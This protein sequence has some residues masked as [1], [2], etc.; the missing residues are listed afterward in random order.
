MNLL[1]KI[2]RQSTYIV[3]TSEG[4]RLPIKT[5]KDK[6]VSYVYFRRKQ[7]YLSSIPEIIEADPVFDYVFGGGFLS[8]PCPA[9]DYWILRWRMGRKITIAEFKLGNN[10]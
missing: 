7:I 6:N 4:I 3:H 2:K 1:Y 9:M 8:Y 10:L 5:R